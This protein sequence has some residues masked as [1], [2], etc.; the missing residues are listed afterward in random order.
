MSGA[1]VPS[2]EPASSSSG[3]GYNKGID[4]WSSCR[5]GRIGGEWTGNWVE[6]GMETGDPVGPTVGTAQVMGT[7]TA[8]GM[9]KVAEV[10]LISKKGTRSIKHPMQGTTT[11]L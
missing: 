2:E 5:D 9:G 6:S 7:G 3:T 4:Y 1:H 10:G 8:T 11:L